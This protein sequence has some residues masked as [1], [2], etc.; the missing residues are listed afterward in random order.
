MSS[1]VERVCALP[2]RTD[3]WQALPEEIAYLHGAFERI[4]P[5]LDGNGRA[6]RLLT[7]LILVRMG[8]PPAVILKRER[9]RYLDAL[10]AT[11]DGRV[12]PLGDFLARAILDTLYRFVVPAVDGPARL[13]PLAGLVDRDIT[14]R[15]LRNA[16]ERGRLKAQRGNDGQWRSSRKW[17]DDYK[18]SRYKRQSRESAQPGRQSN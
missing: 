4:H 9:D 16:A 18:E 1:W 7:N 15:A 6:G 2:T 3:R 5:F 8:H 14:A 17:V 10:R 11:D 13:V 12:G